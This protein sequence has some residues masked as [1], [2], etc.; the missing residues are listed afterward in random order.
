[1]NIAFIMDPWN[2]IKVEID[3]TLLL[4]QEAVRRGHTVG[5]TCPNNLGIRNSEALGNFKILEKSKNQ[6]T[7]V[8]SFYKNAVFREQQLPISGFDVIFLRADPPIDNIMLNFL[9]TVK[10]DTFIIND[11]DGLRKANNKL[12]HASFYDPENDFI[13][14]THVSKNKNYLKHIIEESKS[15]KMILKPLNGFG[16][17][18]VIVVEKNATQNIKSLLDFYIN[19]QGE[20]SYV[21]LQEFVPGAENGDVRIVLL[22]GE[23]IGAL[24][25]VPA[26]DDI[27]SNISAGGSI[28]KHVLTAR[29]KEICRKMGPMLVQDGLYWVGLDVINGKVIEINVI[30]PGGIPMINKLNRTRL[31]DKFLDY[32]ENVVSDRHSAIQRKLDHRKTV[33]NI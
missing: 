22:H 25:R 32:V 30:S 17:R 33:S 6:S 4:I 28:E 24:R 18:G 10:D 15:D 31:Q 11:I 2:K 9:D 26:R 21:I 12:Y 29:E 13:P 3:S 5:I 8:Q 27:R 19:G 20:S 23:P 7:K 14:V 1:M 16:G